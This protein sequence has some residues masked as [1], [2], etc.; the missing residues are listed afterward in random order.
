MV[1]H[2]KEKKCSV[3][4]SDSSV[5]QEGENCLSLHHWTCSQISLFVQGCGVSSI[6][7]WLLQGH[8]VSSVSYNNTGYREM[9]SLRDERLQGERGGEVREL[10]SGICST[11]PHEHTHFL[12]R[13]Y[14]K[15]ISPLGYQWNLLY[16]N[17]AAIFISAS[18]VYITDPGLL[19]SD[20]TC[21]SIK[22][23]ANDSSPQHFVTFIESSH[24]PAVC[25]CS[26]VHLFKIT[27]NDIFEKGHGGK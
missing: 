19:P 13:M 3:H 25:V 10:W 24:E 22:S 16:S 8:S 14:W 7:K 2:V 6:L 26:C 17:L 20:L 23:R 9:G 27:T 4:K 1:Q 21:N 5:L 12:G 15:G 11:S 18:F